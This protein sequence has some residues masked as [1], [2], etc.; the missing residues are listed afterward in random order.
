MRIS[1]CFECF[2]FLCVR[3]DSWLSI[4]SLR[5]YDEGIPTE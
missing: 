5:K 3:E 2:S 1:E 4:E